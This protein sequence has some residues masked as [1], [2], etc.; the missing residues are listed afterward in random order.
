MTPHV[1]ELVLSVNYHDVH[2]FEPAHEIMALFVL[3]KLILQ[4]RMRSYLVG[5]DV[6][7]LEGPFTYFHT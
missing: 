5:L 4:T 3:C 2:L 6:R 7:F 1:C